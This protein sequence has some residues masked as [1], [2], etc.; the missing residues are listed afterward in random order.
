MTVECPKCHKAGRW[1]ATG[2]FDRNRHQLRRAELICDVCRYAFSS[3]LPEAMA[4]GE[5]VAATFGQAP[6]APTPAIPQ[7]LPLEVL[8]VD[9]CEGEPAAGTAGLPRLARRVSSSTGAT[10]NSMTRVGTLAVDYRQRQTGEN[11]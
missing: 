3:G 5:L 8:P 9:P 11:G 7:P 2:R 1:H 10:G 4:A 6:A